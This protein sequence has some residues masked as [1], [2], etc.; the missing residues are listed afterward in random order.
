[1]AQT[2]MIK[3]QFTQGERTAVKRTRFIVL[4][5]L[6][7][8]SLFFILEMTYLRGISSQSGPSKNLYLLEAVI[9]LIRNDYLEEKDPLQIA[10][11][12]FKGLVN[13]LD[14]L[15]SYLDAE[16]TVRYL[17]RQQGPLQEPGIVLFK[18]YGAF[19]QV[20]GIVENSPADNQSL[21]FGDLITEIDGLSTPA[22]SLMEVNLRLG[23]REGKPLALKALRGEK[24]IEIKMER[25]LL[26]PENAS[27]AAHE[28]TSGILSIHR[29]FPP[30]VSEIRTRFLP[31]L[32]KRKEPL[33]IDLRN[34][35]EGNFEEA[36]QFI[37]LF[38]KADNIGCL[39]K[40]GGEK[41]T[42][43]SPEAPPLVRLPLIVWINQGTL[44]PAE[45][46]AAVLK[47]FD[48]AKLVGLETPGLSAEYQF[49]LLEDG[50]SVV[51]TSGI[52][53][54]NSGA[55][56]WGRGAKPDIKVEVDG[57]GVQSFLDKTQSLLS[58]S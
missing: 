42:L 45:A 48:R 3:Y 22:M 6:F 44:G 40:K 54:L 31:E 25:A 23:D 17:E 19:P 9:R 30:C 8:I 7:G 5:L 52:F 43:A 29:I 10:D 47:E 24:T 26:H 35:S 57:Q 11:G 32:R 36:R 38:L 46:V 28:G 12:S 37:N 41:Q 34:C 16:S 2:K 49:Y 39:E 27:Y 14:S 4:A 15:S 56:L 1:M 55:K 33:I 18:R 51:L 20:T 50:T 21:E 13:S 53:C 58:V